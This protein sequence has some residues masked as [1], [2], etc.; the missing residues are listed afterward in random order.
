MSAAAPPTVLEKN[1]APTQVFAP[2]TPPVSETNSLHSAQMKAAFQPVRATHHD[3]QPDSAAPSNFQS[4]YANVAQ[5]PVYQNSQSAQ[6]TAN[7]YHYSPP[8]AGFPSSAPPVAESF[9]PSVW[10]WFTELPAFVKIGG[11][12]LIFSILFAVALKVFMQMDVSTVNTAA[13]PTEPQKPWFS[14]W[15][16]NG[17]NAEEI[18]EKHETETFSKGKIL[19]SNGFVVSGKARIINVSGGA[20]DLVKLRKNPDEPFIPSIKVSP[21]APV[22]GKTQ[23]NNFPGR[24][25]F[26]IAFDISL[27]APNRLVMQM[28]LKPKEGFT[29]SYLAYK[30]A[31]FD[32]ANGWHFTKTVM[33]GRETLNEEPNRSNDF[34]FNHTTDSVTLAIQKSGYSNLEL[35]GEEVVYNRRAYKVKA[36]N[37]AGEASE[38][39]FDIETG[40]AVK[41][42]QNSNDIYFLDYSNFNGASYPSKIVVPMY[43]EYFLLSIDKIQSNVPLDDSIFRRSSYR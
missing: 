15:F 38:I 24:S 11:A 31:G 18:F 10:Y 39:C 32:G 6:P 20:L 23:Q 26:D 17:P 1:A 22:N 43:G 41:V 2:Q 36:K 34:F 30:T 27:K 13:A 9:K 5:P 21:A 40:L 3:F 16:R 14:S 33:M 25:D 12:V 19:S 42:R 8:R 35:V 29:Q 4:K 28:L 37:L 7:A